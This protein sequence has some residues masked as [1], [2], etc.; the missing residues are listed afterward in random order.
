MG[1]FSQHL[2]MNYPDFG[3]RSRETQPQVRH[4]VISSNLAA[5]R[6]AKR[7]PGYEYFA[8]G[9]KAL[10]PQTEHPNALP[11]SGRRSG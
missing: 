9:W 6:F 5:A 11:A 10:L 3:F 1:R 8:S 4:K 2:Q 7:G